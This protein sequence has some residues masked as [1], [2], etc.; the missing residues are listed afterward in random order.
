[1]PEVVPKRLV[2]L[3]IE[4]TVNSLTYQWWQRKS[5]NAVSERFSYDLQMKTREQSRNNKRTEIERFDWFSER[6]QRAWLFALTSNCNNDWPIEQCLLHIKVFFGGKTKRPCFDLFIHQLIKQITLTGSI[7]QGHTKIAL[8]LLTTST[9]FRAR[10]AGEW[11]SCI[12]V[13]TVGDWVESAVKL[14]HSWGVLFHW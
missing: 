6:K 7:F 8:S 14:R 13:T 3:S 5:Y 12:K 9:E 10:S 11:N 4:T 2:G 1:M